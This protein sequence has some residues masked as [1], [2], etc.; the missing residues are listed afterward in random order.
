MN[1]VDRYLQAVRFFL[2]QK[3]QDDLIRELSE[4]LASQMEDSEEQLGRPLTEEEVSDILRR[5]GHPAVVAG[6]YAPR[7]LLIGPALFPIY[8][9]VLKLG[10]AAALAVTVILSVMAAAL[11]GNAV[12][13]LLQ[14]LF[15]YPGRALMVFAWTTAA[16]A[17]LEFAQSRMKLQYSWD[18]RKLPKLIRAE[19]RISRPE[20]VCEFLVASGAVIVLILALRTKFVVMGPLAAFLDLTPV[21]S[22]VYVPMLVLTAAMAGLALVRVVKPYWTKAQS[23]ARIALDTARLVLVVT[24]MRAGEW[25]T[26]KPGMTFSNDVPVERIVEI[27]N[28]SIL[29]GLAITLLVLLFEIA[30]EARRLYLRQG[31][32]ASSALAML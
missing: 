20:S 12:E 16:F 22:Q 27:A 29:I 19:D 4:N 28:T 5:H 31:R 17:A 15:G 18:P 11:G 23:Y 21:W 32:H 1:L 7:Q 26:A 6:R 10:L 2:P 9:F 30:R 25:V 24:L 3:Q 14:G 13:S 8:A